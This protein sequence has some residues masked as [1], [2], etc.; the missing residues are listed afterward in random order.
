[1]KIKTIVYPV[2]L[3]VLAAIVAASSAGYAEDGDG[4]SLASWLRTKDD[5]GMIQTIDL[6]AVSRQGFDIELQEVLIE[7]Q[8]VYFSLVIRWDEA[9][10][11][12]SVQ[13]GTIEKGLTIGGESFDLAQDW[14]LMMRGPLSEETRRPGMRHLVSMARLPKD[15][16][17][18]GEIP[19]RLE[20]PKLYLTFEASF[21]QKEIEGPWV[22]E[23]TVDG[24][25]MNELTRIVPLNSRIQTGRQ[26]YQAQEL[27]YSP[28]RARVH[29]VWDFSDQTARI[30]RTG[31]TIFK[32]FEDRNL[33]GFI[34]KDGAGNQI[35]LTEPDYDYSAQNSDEPLTAFEFDLYSASLEEDWAWLKDAEDLT[36]TPY[37]VTLF[38]PEREADGIERYHALEPIPIRSKVADVESFM[39]DFEPEYSLWDLF[40]TANPY[41]KPVRLTQTTES[42]IVIMLDKVLVTE[43]SIKVSVLAGTDRFDKNSKSL[44][45]FE[46]KDAFVEVGPIQPY[47]PDYIEPIYG[48]GGGG[49]EPFI[50]DVNDDPLVIMN[51]ISGAL[52]Y[53]DGF[54]SAKEP[55]QAKVSISAVDVCW[56]E[57]GTVPSNAWSCFTEEGPFI[58]EFETDGAELA[59]LTKEIELDK[60]ITVEGQEL[61]LKRIR[62]NPLDVILFIDGYRVTTVNP[63]FDFLAAFIEADDGTTLSL[64]PWS[65]PFSGFERMIV[66]AAANES[67][68]KTETL[69]I[70]I[71]TGRRHDRPIPDYDPDNM[72]FFSCDPA[73]ST[74][75]DLK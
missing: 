14:D 73:W 45:G 33:L 43:N 67:L 39:A 36:L 54:V 19:I 20:I 47:P 29:L 63:A 23:F 10:D 31:N 17:P 8:R 37:A 52:M 59:A 6:P 68:A 48:G 74:T 57:S 24:S 5:G 53:P 38:G 3:L 51:L 70:H 62:F 9:A 69:K 44:T 40:D 7:D 56:D 61:T 75:V 18:D 35:E 50:N 55:I 21:E 13:I 1:M 32:N 22:F 34:L 60:T 16:L 71:C 64:N 25:P 66:D 72:K 28:I 27:V 15:A 11:V 46:I 30:N 26:L 42:G 4:L 41:V 49:G 58:F 12:Q 65:L 2:L